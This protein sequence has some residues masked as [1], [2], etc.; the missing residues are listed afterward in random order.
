MLLH[1]YNS[2]GLDVPRY[3]SFPKLRTKC[4][5]QPS[6]ILLHAVLGHCSDRPFVASAVRPSKLQKNKPCTQSPF[7]LVPPSPYTAPKINAD[8][9]KEPI[10]RQCTLIL[11]QAFLRMLALR[12]LLSLTETTPCRRCTSFL[13]YTALLEVTP[14]SSVCEILQPGITSHITSLTLRY[15]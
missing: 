9:D 6:A 4:L 1:A 5:L 8:P 10:R 13:F 11:Y 15:D 2:I 3:I 7:K 14:T 12:R